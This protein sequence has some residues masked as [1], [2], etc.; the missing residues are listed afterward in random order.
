MSMQSCRRIALA[1]CAIAVLGP[2][3][4]HAED[5]WS[6]EDFLSDYSK[7]EPI[8]TKLGDEFVY[9]APDAQDRLGN[10]RAVMIDQPEVRFSESSKTKGAKPDDLTAIAEL[11]RSTLARDLTARG[12]FVVDKPGA[13]VLYM[14]LAVSHLELVSKKR[15]V[16]A[17]TPVGFVVS[18]GIRATQDFMQKT[19]ILD[20]ALQVEV[21]DSTTHDVLGAA[22]LKQGKGAVEGA[23]R[24]PERMSFDELVS[25]VSE[26]SA[27]VACRLDNGRLPIEQRIDCTDEAAR[28]ARPRVVTQ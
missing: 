12:Y 8:H 2:S 17:Y 15:G 5:K 10:Y 13:E 14:R 1:A 22:V 21:L 16:L 28:N 23:D 20:L 18:S 9:L 24:K 4:A 7:L 11:V 19:D 6:G 26:G 27:R 25:T 3:A